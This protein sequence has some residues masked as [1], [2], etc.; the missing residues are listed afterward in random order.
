MA[1]KQV[2]DVLSEC[3]WFGEC[4]GERNQRMLEQSCFCG[5]KP[6]NAFAFCVN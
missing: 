2:S 3:E 6:I 1:V 4:F 5:S